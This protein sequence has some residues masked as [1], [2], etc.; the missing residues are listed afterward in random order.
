[1][2]DPVVL[3]DGSDRPS[4]RVVRELIELVASLAPKP[5]VRT[6]HDLDGISQGL[7]RP[8]VIQAVDPLPI[9]P[10][11]VVLGSFEAPPEHQHHAGEVPASDFHRGSGLR[12]S[13]LDWWERLA[14]LGDP[15]DDVVNWPLR[16]DGRQFGLERL[17]SG[18]KYLP[19]HGCDRPTK[20]FWCVLSTV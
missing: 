4:G 5:G 3:Q 1:M 2:S 7:E 15:A 9:P 6:G 12:L 17:V 10:R 13:L 8:V 11:R 16:A 20:A 14:N 18:V 19:G